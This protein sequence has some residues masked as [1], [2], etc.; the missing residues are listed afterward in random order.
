MTLAKDTAIMLA[1]YNKRWKAML[2]LPRED[3]NLIIPI[4]KDVEKIIDAAEKR[5]GKTDEDLQAEFTELFTELFK[6]EN[7]G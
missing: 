4:L 5:L 2:D 6:E 3:R 1:D 7:N